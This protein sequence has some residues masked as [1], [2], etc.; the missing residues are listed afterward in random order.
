MGIFN[1]IYKNLREK[2]EEKL[3]FDLCK[4]NNLNLSYKDSKNDLDILKEIFIDR[5]YS[6]YFPFYE[7]SIIFDIGAHKGFF[8]L[9]AANNSGSKSKIY[10]FEP[11]IKN[12]EELKINIQKNNFNEKVQSFNFG[13]SDKESNINLYLNKS[14]NNSIFSEHSKYLNLNQDVNTY[15]IDVLDLKE[16]FNITKVGYIDFIKIDC[17]GAEYPFIFNAD[18]SYLK[19][20]KTISIEFHDLKNKE[21]SGLNLV[22]FF[23]KNGFEVNKFQYEKTTIANNFG[24]LIV[25]RF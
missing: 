9:F 15:K 3:F 7:D 13:V 21:Y 19:K 5:C 12:F 20:I 6:D 8:S 23:K 1:F 17:E 2:E 10:A 11:F 18:I 14:E 4:N 24:K 25:T 22:K 16:L